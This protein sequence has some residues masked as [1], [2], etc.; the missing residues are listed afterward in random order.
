[1]LKSLVKIALGH[2]TIDGT[3]MIIYQNLTKVST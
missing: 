1:M 3:I 2:V